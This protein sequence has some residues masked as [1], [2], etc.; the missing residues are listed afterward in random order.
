MKGLIASLL[1]IRPMIGVDKETGKYIQMGQ[2]RS[3]ENTVKGIVSLI[4]R[5]YEP[6]SELRVQV[7]HA[8]NLSGAEMLREQIEK[9]FKCSWLP[10]GQLSLV[11]GAHTGPS[12]VGVA[13]A[14][15]SIFADLPQA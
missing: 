15:L 6:G 9:V 12:M 3:F 5:Q 7:V 4:S 13:F 8:Q 1:H 10:V 14:P 2:A 11:L